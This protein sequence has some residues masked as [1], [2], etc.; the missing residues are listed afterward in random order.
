LRHLK[1]NLENA[2]ENIGKVSLAH[3]GFF[4]NEFLK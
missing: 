4:R 1:M 3:V 2:F